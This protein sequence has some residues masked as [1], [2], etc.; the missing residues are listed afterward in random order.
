MDI[1]KQIGNHVMPRLPPQPKLT[2][3]AEYDIT[4]QSLPAH[5]ASLQTFM[6]GA[7]P[8]P[9]ANMPNI[10]IVQV[11]QVNNGAEHFAVALPTNHSIHEN[12]GGQPRW[13]AEQMRHR[14]TNPRALIMGPP[15]INFVPEKKTMSFKSDMVIPKANLP[16]MPNF[17]NI[18]PSNP[19]TFEARPVTPNLR[20][21][22]LGGLGVSTSKYGQVGMS[23]GRSFGAES[24]LNL[25]L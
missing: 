16:N 15:K 1:V 8:R 17:S 14:P 23:H 4:T 25:T 9:K 6:A 20:A 7:G 10:P 3:F 2:K 19:M 13:E 5:N 24:R 11:P 22:D 18:G 21:K 12:F